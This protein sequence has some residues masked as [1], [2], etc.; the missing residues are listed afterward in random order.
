MD[1]DAL[2]RFLRETAP[3]PLAPPDH[4][5]IDVSGRQLVEVT[6]T[7]EER[8]LVQRHALAA[9]VGGTSRIFSGEE[10]AANL[11]ANQISGQL[12]ELAYHIYLFGRSTG[13]KRYDERRQLRNANKHLG[14]GGE[15]VEGTK[16]DVKLSLWR[17]QKRSLWDHNL[18]V[19]PDERHSGFNYV[20]GLHPSSCK[21]VWLLGWASETQL[22]NKVVETGLFAG[23]FILPARLL[24]PLP[25]IPVP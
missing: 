15:D 16:T 23:A 4:R 20:L 2:A 8:L 24:R 13:A 10:R 11:T 6:I 12:G 25:V 5:I 9:A 17:K 3:P 14:D 21:K 19:R 18:P 22:P 7:H 1:V